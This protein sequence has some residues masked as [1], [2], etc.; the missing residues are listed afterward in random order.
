MF[1]QKGGAR[2][3]LFYSFLAR[4]LCRFFFFSHIHSQFFP[5]PESFRQQKKKGGT[6]KRCKYKKVELKRT[7]FFYNIPVNAIVVT[8][9]GKRGICRLTSEIQLAHR[10]VRSTSQLSR[11]HHDTGDNKHENKKYDKDCSIR[12]TGR[13]YIDSSIVLHP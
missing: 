4:Y 2:F 9:P 6:E 5:C 11:S 10:L 3:L 1:L 8:L 7:R 12:Q 13:F